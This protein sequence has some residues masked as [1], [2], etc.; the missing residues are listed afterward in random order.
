MSKLEA[1]GWRLKGKA[2]K[3]DVFASSFEPR[4]SSGFSPATPSG[5]MRFVRVKLIKMRI[6]ISL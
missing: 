1:R 3:E 6:E 2:K 5:L 4:A